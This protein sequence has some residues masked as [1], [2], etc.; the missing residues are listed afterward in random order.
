M[1]DTT[2]YVS[3]HGIL[4]EEHVPCRRFSLSPALCLPRPPALLQCCRRLSVHPLVLGH[5]CIASSW[6][7][8][9]AAY[10]SPSHPPV[11]SRRSR[12]HQPN[13]DSTGRL[14]QSG[15]QP[16]PAQGASRLAGFGRF[17]RGQSPCI[18]C[19]DD[20]LICSSPESSAMTSRAVST[21]SP[22]EWCIL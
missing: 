15:P 19:Q 11:T 22:Q 14:H 9:P 17:S 18:F 16:C 3:A 6:H 20:T 5:L 13:R 21:L 2:I 4:L 8:E 10:P 12:A 1:V 7:Q